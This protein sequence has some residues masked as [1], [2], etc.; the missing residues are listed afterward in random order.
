M[1]T[2]GSCEAGCSPHRRLRLRNSFEHGRP[3]HKSGP[4]IQSPPALPHQAELQ[5]ASPLRLCCLKLANKTLYRLVGILETILLHQILLDAGRSN[6][7]GSWQQ[8]PPPTVRSNVCAQPQ[9]RYSKWLVLIRPPPYIFP[10]DR[11]GWFC[12]PQIPA[13]RLA[14]DSQLVRNPS[15]R[16]SAIS[17][18]VNRCLQTHFAE[19]GHA[20]LNRFVPGPAEKFCF[21]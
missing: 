7:P 2:V 11:N 4:P 9:C 17:Q 3:L 14:I 20:P 12:Q 5:C 1:F 6:L 15:L 16:P 13:H 10:G 18:T 21:P 19:I 8:S